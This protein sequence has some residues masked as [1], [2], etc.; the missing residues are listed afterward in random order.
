MADKNIDLRFRGD[1]RNLNKT[2]RRI[3][4]KFGNLG[5]EL[6]S[7]T[8]N[9]ANAFRGLDYI[10]TRA[11]SRIFNTVTGSISRSVVH[12]V[13][14]KDLLHETE[15]K[16]ADSPI[17]GIK[18]EVPWEELE[19]KIKSVA[20]T[21]KFTQVEIAAA[22]KVMGMAGKSSKEIFDLLRPAATLSA[23]TNY[24]LN[25]SIGLLIETMNQ[26]GIRGDK[27][28]STIATMVRAT[29]MSNMS[30]EQFREGFKR[31]G[32]L[33]GATKAPFEQV[34]ALL[35][36]LAN[37]GIKASVADTGLRN[38]FQAM[39]MARGGRSAKLMKS[40]KETF[41]DKGIKW[42]LPNVIQ[43]VSERFKDTNKQAQIFKDM[44]GSRAVAHALL[45][46]KNLD[47]VQR[48]YN[49]L[50]KDNV[51][52]LS[53]VEETLMKDTKEYKLMLSA[54]DKLKTAWGTE[55]LMNLKGTNTELKKTFN[56]MTSI[57]KGGGV[58][59]MWGETFEKLIKVY[60]NILGGIDSLT[61]ARKKFSERGD[62]G[63]WKKQA[64][65]FFEGA[66]AISNRKWRQ[67]EELMNRFNIPFSQERA[68]ANIQEG[69]PLM[70]RDMERGARMGAGTPEVMKY[71]LD[72]QGAPPG[73]R[74]RTPE[75]PSSDITFNL[76][77]QGL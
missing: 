77:F 64:G 35:T 36:V 47:K 66:K 15:A 62:S 2:F 58:I 46:S 48:N 44:F 67:N 38:M 22:T 70:L 74:L 26:F 59:K 12:A 19:K 16:M 40:L 4:K 13:S 69:P 33:A 29:N 56:I 65:Y 57:V 10:T 55:W 27:L 63:F 7:S 9:L 6:K 60:N 28:N 39:A 51:G 18:P 3:N 45:L 68:G 72:I 61:K 43:A 17:Y 41:A 50:L 54:A 21:T 30:M 75:R 8:A 73:S 25:D 71:V 32:A 5:R 23:S 11:V 76:G 37:V 42:T 20:D 52:L 34:S 1:D 49:I 31:A 24:A 14:V 53:K